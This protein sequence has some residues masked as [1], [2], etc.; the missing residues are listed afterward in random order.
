MLDWSHLLDL[1]AWVV[2][3]SQALPTRISAGALYVVTIMVNYVGEKG[4]QI[5][6]IQ[7]IIEIVNVVKI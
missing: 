6:Q 5:P 2:Q 1:N 3:K 4:F 7:E